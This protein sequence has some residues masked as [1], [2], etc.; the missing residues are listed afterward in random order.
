M[1]SARLHVVL[2]SGLLFAVTFALF[3]PATSFQLVNFDDPVFITH[4][5]IIFNGFSWGGL[6]SAFTGLHGDETMYVPLLWISYL[7]DLKFL[8]ASPVNPWGFHFTNGLLHALNS[9]L[10]F[11]LLFAFCKKPWR[12]FFFAA[13]WA[14]HPLRVES[15]AW[16]TERKDVLSTFFALLCVGAYTWAWPQRIGA[17]SPAPPPGRPSLLLYGA[18]FIFFILGLLV[19]PMLVTIPFLLLLLDIWPLRRVEL[20]FPSV[21][22]AAP[23]LLFEKWPLFLCAVGASLAVYL[24]QTHSITSVSLW[25]RLY[26]IP[27]NYLFYL[28]KSFFPFHLFAMVPRAPVSLPSF[29]LA[30]GILAAGCAWVWS[31]RQTHANELVGWLAFLGLLF[32]VIGIVLIGIHPVADRYSYLPAIGLSIAFLFSL[33]SGKHSP[34]PRVFRVLRPGVAL[35]ILVA[36]AVLTSRLLPSWKNDQS[37]YDNIARKSPGNYAAIHYQAREE[38]YTHGNFAAA[39]RMADRLLQLRPHVSL[40]LVLKIVCLSQLQSAETALDFAQANYPPSDNVTNPGVY[41]NYLTMIAFLA[42]Q[43]ELA[44]H[45]M[46]ETLRKSVYEPKT[47]E[48]FHA[49]AMLLAHVQGDEASARAHAAQITSLQNKNQLAPEDYFLAYTA[50]WANGFYAQTLPFFQELAHT[51][52]N[53]PDLLNNMAWLLATTAGSPADPAEILK[54]VRQALSGSPDHPVILDTLAVA[55]ANA[56]DFSGA[57]QTA[58]RLSLVLRLSSAT[59]APIMLRGVQKRIALYREHK[60]Y[61]ESA[62]I[63]LLYAP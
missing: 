21:A 28:T 7:F 43:Y 61:R 49:L 46:Q 19:K 23:R 33:S 15:V 60:P 14:L 35:G 39:D 57:L 25:A 10:F 50:L 5:P 32:P 9:V 31:R 44:N 29:L 37:L 12:A 2:L 63:R 45:Y 34:L 56:G 51:H 54:M 26:C 1:K 13:L 53:R 11:L 17:K 38:L 47:Q 30:I 58:E 3:F 48:Q 27:G 18:S 59:D 8:G 22:R 24:T 41:E 55:Q 40:G 6:R 4:N 16:V 52:P 20:S 36:L 62:S 42:R